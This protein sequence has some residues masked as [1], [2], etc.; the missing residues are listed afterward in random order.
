M[1]WS[2]DFAG[3]VMAGIGGTL[4]PTTSLNLWGWA[5]QEK[6]GLHPPPPDFDW[7]QWCNPMNS[8]QPWNGSIAMN[9]PHTVQGYRS[10]ADGCAATVYTLLNGKYDTIVQSLRENL[11]ASWWSETARNQLGVWGTG[12]S[13]CDSVPIGADVLSQLDEILAGAKAIQYALLYGRGTANVDPS[14]YAAV[15]FDNRL[16]AAL[17]PVLDAIKAIPGGGG[18]PEPAEPPETP[19]VDLIPL[20]NAVQALTADVLALQNKISGLTLRIV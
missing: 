20:T 4:T 9:P 17:K 19:A 8:E 1:I 14:G 5:A 6:T 3:P 13:W 12:A 15:D 16:D 2:T 10:I 7:F 18:S 11:P